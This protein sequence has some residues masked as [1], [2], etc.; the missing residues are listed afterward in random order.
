MH[1]LRVFCG[2][3]GSGGNPPAVFLDGAAQL[4]LS[5]VG[6]ALKAT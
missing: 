6:A 5:G 3:G 1:L 2:E 4:G